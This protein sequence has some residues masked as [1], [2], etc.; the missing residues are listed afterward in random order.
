MMKVMLSRFI[1]RIGPIPYTMYRG[2]QLTGIRGNGLKKG[3]EFL[4]ESMESLPQD[5]LPLAS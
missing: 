5:N 2:V 4:F 1:S 3:L